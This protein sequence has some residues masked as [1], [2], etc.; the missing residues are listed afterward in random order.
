MP[1]TQGKARTAEAHCSSQI[2][3]GFQM[4]PDRRRDLHRHLLT[5]RCQRCRREAGHAVPREARGRAGWSRGRWVQSSHSL[6]CSGE[7]ASSCA[8]A[9]GLWGIPVMLLC[10][11]G[12]MSFIPLP[13]GIQGASSHLS[14][15][16]EQLF[17]HFP[18]KDLSFVQQ[19]VH[20][21]STRQCS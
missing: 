10:S 17:S 18:H 14:G 5:A 2:A 1:R 3:W 11:S 9:P 4:V 15:C 20:A 7:Q 21:G 16:R 6:S 8:A 13:P 12:G 19:E